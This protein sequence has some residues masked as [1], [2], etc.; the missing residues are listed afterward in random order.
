MVHTG[1]RAGVLG[2]A[3]LEAGFDVAAQGSP[4]PR[5]DVLPADLCAAVV[6]LYRELGGQQ[7]QPVLRPGGW[8]LALAGGVVIELD[9][10]L[11]FNRYR[12]RTLAEPWAR[13]LP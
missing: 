5:L 1:A 11:H 8:D 10:E 4:A 12:A 2:A 13:N 9:E 6:A 7:E 3:L